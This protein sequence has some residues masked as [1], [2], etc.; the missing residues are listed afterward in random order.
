MKIHKSKVDDD[1]SLYAVVRMG[2]RLGVGTWAGGP[3]FGKFGIG[4]AYVR[5]QFLHMQRQPKF[6]ASPRPEPLVEGVDDLDTE[7]VDATTP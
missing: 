1:L 7:E 6:E 2:G 4:R 3:E 5:I